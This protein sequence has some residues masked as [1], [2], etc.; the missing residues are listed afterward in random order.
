[1]TEPTHFFG[2]VYGQRWQMSQSKLQAR[3]HFSRLS[4]SDY[5]LANMNSF[6]E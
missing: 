3:C 2:T 6:E 1:M 4:Y 5:A